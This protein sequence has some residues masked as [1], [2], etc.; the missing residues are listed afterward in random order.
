[1]DHVADDL[2][3]PLWSR[4]LACLG[5][6][7]QVVRYDGRGIGLSD[8]D[9]TDISFD[10]FVLDLETVVDSLGVEKVCLVGV[11]MG[12]AAAIA[13][14]A[15]YP[16]RVD[17]LV[18]HGAF[19]VGRRRRNSAADLEQADLFLA[20][21]RQGWGKP[22]PTFMKAFACIYFPQASAEK[23]QWFAELQRRNAAPET[24]VRI[25]AV[26]DDI[27]VLDLLPSIRAPALVTNSRNDQVVPVG[28]GRTV[29]SLLPHGRFLALDSSNHMILSDDPEADRF[30]HAVDEFLAPRPA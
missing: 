7:R 14:A 23:L 12:A 16:E 10:K 11:S 20:L 24:A 17:K 9:V 13:F 19:A 2:H 4:P 6:G 28:N 8:R 1:M 26:C 5:H 22:D 27:D 3:N 21:M 15:R 30:A 18:L 25:R 29:A